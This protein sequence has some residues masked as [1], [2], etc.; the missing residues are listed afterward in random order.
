MLNEQ[1]AIK[2]I[3]QHLQT[4]SAELGEV[5]LTMPFNDATA[6]LK[7]YF[8]SGWRVLVEIEATEAS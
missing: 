3:K 2:Q 5:F 7:C 6:T 4:S 8:I 1:N